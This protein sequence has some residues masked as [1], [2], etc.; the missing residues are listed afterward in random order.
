MMYAIQSGRET[1]LSALICNILGKSGAEKSRFGVTY[2]SL[3]QTEQVAQVWDI[4]FERAYHFLRNVRGCQRD[5]KESA[6]TRL[7]L[8]QDRLDGVIVIVHR[9]E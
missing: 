6:Q 5:R 4:H 1:L 9:A 2:V 3:V 7:V 8:S